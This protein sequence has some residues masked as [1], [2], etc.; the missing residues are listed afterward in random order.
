M[1]DLPAAVLWDMD[2]TL[3]DTEPYWIEAEQ[4]L[5]HR[6]GATW[7]HE[8]AMALV[9]SDLIDS[10]TYIRERMGLDL[11]PTQIVDLLLDGV[12]QKVARD[13]PW[14]PGARELL[15]ALGGSGVPCALVTMSWRRFVEPVLDQLPPGSFTHVVTGDEVTRGKPHPDPYLRAAELLGVDPRACVAIEDSPTGA[16]SAA[17]AGCPVLVVPHHVPVPPASRLSFAGTLEGLGPDDLV[18]LTRLGSH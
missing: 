18:P 11:T 8:D 9:G 1:T 3:V 12:V 10:G 13:V 4:E 14:R 5:A 7:T 2:G 17:A 16:A 15:G 6:H